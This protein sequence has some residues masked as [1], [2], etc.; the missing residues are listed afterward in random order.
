MRGQKGQQDLEV[1]GDGRFGPQRVELGG[2]VHEHLAGTDLPGGAAARSW[3]R[4]PALDQRLQRRQMAEISVL[5]QPAVERRHVGGRQRL[6]AGSGKAEMRRPEQR[7]RRAARESGAD[8]GADQVERGRPRLS[9]ERQSVEHLARH[10]R[11][12]QHLARHVHIW[13]RRPHDEG[14]AIEPRQRPATGGGLHAAGKAGHLLF[15]VARLMHQRAARRHDQQRI[16]SGSVR[17][18]RANFV[19]AR[20]QVVQPLVHLAR[21]RGVGDHDVEALQPRHPRQQIPVRRPEPVR[22]ARSIADRHHD[23]TAGTVRG[24]FNQPHA[25]RVLVGANGG[26]T[27]FE[28]AK[29][30]GEKPCLPHQPLRAAVVG[31]ARL[32]QAQGEALERL[33]V[34]LMAAERVVEAQHLGDEAWTQTEGRLVP[35]G[36]RGPAGHHGEGFSFGIPQDLRRRVEPFRQTEHQLARG[37]EIGQ[38]HCL[39]LTQRGLD[40][41]HELRGRRAGRYNDEP[42]TGVERRAFDR[43][44]GDRTPE[45]LEVRHSDQACRTRG[46]H[47][48]RGNSR[49]SRMLPCTCDSSM[50]APAAAEDASQ[51]RPTLP[52]D[53]ASDRPVAAVSAKRQEPTSRL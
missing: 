43:Q 4:R 37:H 9:G 39:F 29:R 28:L 36:T 50:R 53:T 8:G 25:Q 38:D 44:L 24:R 1:G 12:A 21:Q 23:V 6:A 34:F 18:I 46:D 10:T 26:L 52:L 13:Q 27:R 45:R 2:Q 5:R 17:R 20:Q 51:A 41:P 14:G 40:R 32:E 42:V 11:R 48:R 49:R 3:L 16:G 22:I 7:N 15:A 33:H 30:R 31:S 47:F 19:D 35:G